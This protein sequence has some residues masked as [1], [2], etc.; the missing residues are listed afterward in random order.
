MRP[1][2]TVSELTL[3]VRRLTIT[4][5]ETAAP[6]DPP[7][8]SSAPAVSRSPSAASFELVSAS[9]SSA[10]ARSADSAFFSAASPAKLS[11]LDLGLAQSLVNQL[12]GSDSVWTP[13]T[14]I[15]RPFPEPFVLD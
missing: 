6:A 2:P 4:V 10:P 1:D 9:A 11:A 13:H 12:R 14:R 3:Q 15:A 5:R 7:S 8:A